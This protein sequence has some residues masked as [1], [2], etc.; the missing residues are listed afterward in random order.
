ML[1]TVIACGGNPEENS[2]DGVS[3]ANELLESDA[4]QK[5]D[6]SS[7]EISDDETSYDDASSNETSND[8]V[9]YQQCRYYLMKHY[10]DFKG[11]Y[12][13]CH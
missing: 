10:F 4:D 11:Q 6:T 5:D 13:F 7:D 3:V 1:F 8:T 9:F 12:I 2:Q